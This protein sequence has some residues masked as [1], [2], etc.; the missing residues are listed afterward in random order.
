MSYSNTFALA[1]TLCIVVAVLGGLGAFLCLM[2]RRQRSAA[3]EDGRESELRTS[4]EASRARHQ[5]S[6]AHLPEAIPLE[7]DPSNGGPALGNAFIKDFN[8]L[9]DYE[10]EFVRVDVANSISGTPA[11]V[12]PPSNSSGSQWGSVPGEGTMISSYRQHPV[13]TASPLAPVN[14]Q[15][16]EVPAFPEDLERGGYVIVECDQQQERA[17][18]DFGTTVAAASNHQMPSLKEAKPARKLEFYRHK[19]SSA[20]YGTAQYY[21]NPF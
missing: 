3:A 4:A 5:G 9:R 7:T 16:T 21:N 15:H 12:P 18:N 6:R 13:S 10:G 14:P 19:S 2:A 8:I 11:G 20:V 1:V 17:G